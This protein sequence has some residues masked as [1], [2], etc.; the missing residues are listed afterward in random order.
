MPSSKLWSL[1]F[2]RAIFE[3]TSSDLDT[4][5]RLGVEDKDITQLL[6]AARDAERHDE[7]D[8]FMGKLA[9]MLQSRGITP[10]HAFLAALNHRVLRIGTPTVAYHIMHDL[11]TFWDS[12][13][14]YHG[15]AIDLR[16]FCNVAIHADRLGPNL[17][18][19]D[20]RHFLANQSGVQLSR[21]DCVG[22]LMG[23]LWPRPHE[24]RRHTLQSWSP[25]RDVDF[26]DPA[27]VRELLLF[28]GIQELLLSDPK[29]HM[30][31]ERAISKTGVVRIR[32]TA[33]DV[34]ALQAALFRLVAE[35]VDVSFL[36]LYPVIEQIRRQG[37]EYVATVVLRGVI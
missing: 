10:G 25:F 6:E 34:H 3:L 9:A 11:V 16:V 23:L 35:P 15:I 20:L 24:V 36:Q 2:C 19:D 14:A 26:S 31:F 30:K 12:L 4:T 29:W 21:S 5:V 7:R 1:Q 17:Q 28:D 32:A 18:G 22:V 37:Q 33:D 27:L 13:E 8:H